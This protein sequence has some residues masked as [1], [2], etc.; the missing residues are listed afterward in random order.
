M[1]MYEPQREHDLREEAPNLTLTGIQVLL[2]EDE[3]DIAELLV[4]IL[5]CAGADILLTSEASQALEILQHQQ[6]DIL[7]S[8]LR[9]P[10]K[11]GFWLI[12]QV[13]STLNSQRLPAIAVT[14]YLRDFYEES[15]LSNGFQKFFSKFVDPDKL[16]RDIVQLIEE[17]E[18]QK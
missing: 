2:V 4:F 3:L 7:V 17:R 11:D 9:L 1:I 5:K 12:R 14:S 6:P 13:R 10:G 16:V 18:S 8:D 15:A